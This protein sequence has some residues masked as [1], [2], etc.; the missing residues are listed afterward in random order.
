VTL[1]DGTFEIYAHFQP[2]PGIRS[3]APRYG[4]LQETFV[5]RNGTGAYAGISGWGVNYGPAIGPDF[6]QAGTGDTPLWMAE[7]R[8]WISGIDVP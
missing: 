7:M 4:Y 8:G 5:F 1:P 2:V 6:A 3:F